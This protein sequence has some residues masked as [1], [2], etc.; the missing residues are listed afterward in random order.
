VPALADNASM[1]AGAATLLAVGAAAYI[2]AQEIS[3]ALERRGLWT[4]E[5]VATATALSI[6]GFLYFKRNDSDL[7]LLALS[8]V[9]MMASLMLAIAV[10]ACLGAAIRENSANPLLGLV[11]T[12]GGAVILG[13]LAGLFTLTDNLPIKLALLVVGFAIWK[14]REN[15]RPPERSAAL[16]ALEKAAARD[17]QKA[18]LRT[19]SGAP[20]PASEPPSA[21]AARRALIAQRGTLLDRLWPVLVLG[22]LVLVATH[23]DA[24]WPSQSAAASNRSGEMSTLP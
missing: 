10:I 12:I 9:L 16:K 18:T 22:A 19:L 3:D 24:L 6:M 21:E 1:L 17:E 14:L 15:V 8:I 11:A 23:K 4:Q 2:A 7:A 20:R 5:S 13:V